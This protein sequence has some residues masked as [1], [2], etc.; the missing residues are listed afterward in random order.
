VTPRIDHVCLTVEKFDVKR[1]M[2]ALDGLGIK[3]VDQPAGGPQPPLTARVRMRGAEAGGAKEGTP[4][5]YFTDPDGIS[6]QLQD[7]TYCGGAGV[8]GQ[9]CKS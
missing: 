9:I 1:V 2:T 5:L 8:L 7:P 6:I 4:E 3:R